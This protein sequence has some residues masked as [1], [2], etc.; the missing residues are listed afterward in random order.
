MT[1]D[2]VAERNPVDYSDC[3]TFQHKLQSDIAECPAARKKGPKHEL[4]LEDNAR[5]F[6]LHEPFKCLVVVQCPSGH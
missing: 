4:A 3:S 5:G 1:T 2:T 6:V